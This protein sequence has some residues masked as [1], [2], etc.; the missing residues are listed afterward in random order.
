MAESLVLQGRPTEAIP[1]IGELLGSLPDM[2]PFAPWLLRNQG[3][4]LTQLGE[5]EAATDALCTSLLTGRSLGGANDVGF[6]L[7][8]LL[9]CG[10]SDG[11][12][13]EEM[14]AERDEVFARLGVVAVPEVPLS[15]TV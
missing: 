14:R 3:Y 2:H 10:L 11:R 15:A 1:I 6:A 8:A 12:S 7:A 5:R 13:V 9:R 4:A